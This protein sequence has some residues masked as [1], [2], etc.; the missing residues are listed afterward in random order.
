MAKT[1]TPYDPKNPESRQ[2]LAGALQN[3]LRYAGFTKQDGKGEE[4]WIRDIEGS[5]KKT[6][7]VYTSI[8]SGTCRAKGRDAIRVCAVGIHRDGVFKPIVKSTRVFRTGTI[9]A[10]QDRLLARMRETWKKALTRD[11]MLGYEGKEVA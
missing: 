5:P 2:A 4:V 11:W 1:K 3:V 9:E 10:T 6:V 8:Y 7:K